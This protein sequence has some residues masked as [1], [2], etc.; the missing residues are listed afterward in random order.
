MGTEQYT[1]ETC[2]VTNASSFVIGS[3][4]EWANEISAGDIFKIDEDGA[5]TY[6][7]GNVISATKIKLSSN[8]C[9]STNSGLSYMICRS[10]SANRNYYRPQQGDSDWADL[11]SERTIDKIDTDIANLQAG[12]I[13][14]VSKTDDYVIPTTDLN[15]SIR[16]KASTAKRFWFP[17]AVLGNDGSKARIVKTGSG[18]V[19]IYAHPGHKIL[20]TTY[21]GKVFNEYSEEDYATIE[22]EW[23]DDIKKWAG[24]NIFGSWETADPTT[25]SGP[26][27][28]ACIQGPV[29]ETSGF[30][31]CV[32]KKDLTQTTGLDAGIGT[33]TDV[34][35]DALLT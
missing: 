20:D 29:R 6:V 2:S 11:L 16:M 28:D 32:E 19:T 22:L 5:P 21:S 14:V 13:E 10:F 25:A 4:T 18:K 27:F 8:Y 1:A 35:L 26:G 15:K 30:D 23:V 24:V 9:G 34:G 17:N 33:Y 12:I 31:A 7:V 3:D